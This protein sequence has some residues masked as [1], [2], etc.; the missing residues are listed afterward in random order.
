MSSDHSAVTG[1]ALLCLD[2]Q[3]SFLKAIPG[4]AQLQRRCA[5]AI[6]AAVGLGLDVFFTEQVPEKLGPTAPDLLALGPT[7]VVFGKTT[8]S[9]LAHAPLADVLR[10]RSVQHLLIC[11]IETPVCVYQTAIDALHA[12]LQVTLLAD[13]IG[14]RRAD[15][16]AVCLDA[17]ARAG[18]HV[19]P[20][21]TVFYSLLRGADHPFFK[22]YTALVKSH[23]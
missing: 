7:P 8:F 18:V 14:A 1:L 22:A 10:S 16:A 19:L 21:E 6:Q 12:D 23:A 15:D 17:L 20:G 2:V 3:P 4:A 9:A 11:G 5:F 13:C